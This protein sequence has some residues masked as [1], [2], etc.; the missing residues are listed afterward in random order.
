MRLELEL[1]VKTMPFTF[2]YLGNGLFK[3]IKAPHLLSAPSEPVEKHLFKPCY[4]PF[5][6]YHLIL[7]ILI[8]DN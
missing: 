1:P 8:K 7:Y 5:L 4:F 3:I 2:Q 6:F